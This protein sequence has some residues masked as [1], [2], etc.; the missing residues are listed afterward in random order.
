M[1]TTHSTL[2]LSLN[3]SSSNSDKNCLNYSDIPRKLHKLMYF[4]FSSFF[5]TLRCHFVM[6]FQLSAF[7]CN[8]VTSLVLSSHCGSF[9]FELWK[10]KIS[11]SVDEKA[12]K[13][14]QQFLLKIRV[15]RY[16]TPLINNHCPP[17]R[18]LTFAE[19]LVS[20]LWGYEVLH[21]FKSHCIN[22]WE[23]LIFA[24][25]ALRV[26]RL[27]FISDKKRDHGL[28]LQEIQFS[29]PSRYGGVL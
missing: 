11:F 4:L 28:V 14:H 2:K 17:S 8:W 23:T 3:F 12:E 6:L 21:G 9:K 20:S 5:C 19:T 29:W 27:K 22:I 26:K 18:L 1:L 10:W 7:P 16:I 24:E 15:D 13:F 25:N